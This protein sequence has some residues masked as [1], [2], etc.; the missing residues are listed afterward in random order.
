WKVGVSKTFDSLAGITA[1]IAYVGT[2]AP[3][4]SYSS[5]DG[6]NLGRSGVVVS[7]AKTF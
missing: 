5:P 2:D 6:K 7:V 4:G 1:G 3:D